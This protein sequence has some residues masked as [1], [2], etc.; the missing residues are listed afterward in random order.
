VQ[1]LSLLE[2]GHRLT[3]RQIKYTFARVS[4]ALANPTRDGTPSELLRE[5]LDALLEASVEV[6]GPPASTSYAPDWTDLEAWARPPSSD[7]SRPPATAKPP[8]GTA[9]P[10]TPALTR[11]SSAT[12]SKR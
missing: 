11:P 9:P 5:V 1:P 8:G 12:T 10:T 2:S 7:G 3:Y 6:A 4:R